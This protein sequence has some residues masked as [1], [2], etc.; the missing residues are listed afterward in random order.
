MCSFEQNGRQNYALKRVMNLLKCGEVKIF[1]KDSNRSKMNARKKIKEKVKVKL[2]PCL[3]K[4]HF[5]KVCGEWRYS[6]ANS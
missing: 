3:I 5:M 1:G 4:R 2:S 6:A